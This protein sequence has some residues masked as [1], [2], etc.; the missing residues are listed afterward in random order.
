[1]TSD[2]GERFKQRGS[3][4]VLDKARKWFEEHFEQLQELGKDGSILQGVIFGP[5]CDLLNSF[6]NTTE[7]QV[8][9]TITQVASSMQ[10]SRDFLENSVWE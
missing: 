3:K 1:M 5:L 9:R 8:K 10:Y 2:N 4:S 7:D 6:G